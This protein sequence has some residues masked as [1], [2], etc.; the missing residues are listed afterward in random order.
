MTGFAV[1]FV[2]VTG[3]VE[4]VETGVVATTPLVIGFVLLTRVAG[5]GVFGVVDVVG[6]FPVDLPGRAGGVPLQDDSV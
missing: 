4:G 2:A 5:I 3:V 6:C 1:T